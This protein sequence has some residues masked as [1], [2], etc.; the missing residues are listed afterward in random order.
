MTIEPDKILIQDY[1]YDL[2]NERIAHRPLAQRDASK[3]L[4]Y[5]SGRTTDDHFYNLPEHLPANS[6]LILNNTKVIAA[7]MLFKKS[8]GGV[9]EIFCLE[10]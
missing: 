4:V 7:R 5:K 9:I 8:S 1:T 10:P 6:L 2:P 3:L